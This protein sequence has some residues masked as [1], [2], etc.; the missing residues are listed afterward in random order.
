[1]EKKQLIVANVGPLKTEK[2][3]SDKKESLKY[4]MLGTFDAGNPLASAQ[5]KIS[6]RH[7]ANGKA[8]WKNGIDLHMV[9]TSML[10]KPV[11]GA[12]VR[13]DVKPYPIGE[14][15]KAREVS[16][17]TCVVFANETF[18]QVAK[19]QGH[20]M[21]NAQMKAPVEPKAQQEL[22]P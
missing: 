7:D 18:E 16:H 2:V 13:G 20:E 10:G 17:Y 22:I 11:D 12:I 19:E 5:R 1:M 4:F 6:Q 9:Y 15:D 8:V 14:G 21:P 3:R